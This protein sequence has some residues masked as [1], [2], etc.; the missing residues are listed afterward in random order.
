MSTIFYPSGCDDNL[1]HVCSPCPTTENGRVRNIAFVH[2]S[3]AFAD[4]TDPAEWKTYIL[5]KK[6]II[7]AGTNGT[8]DGGAPVLGN[9][10]GSIPKKKTGATYKLAVLDP[11]FIGNCPFYNQL[12]NSTSWRIAWT[13]DTLLQLSDKPCLVTAKDPIAEPVE[14]E[15]Y[16]NLEIEF[17]Q[18]NIPC[19][20]TIPGGIFLCEEVVDEV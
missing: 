13:S 6:I 3:V 2:S 8:Y 14:S 16:W 20:S 17:S 10:F 18:K 7:I 5:A 12:S 11:N 19:H 9:G 15:R 4:I 1:Q